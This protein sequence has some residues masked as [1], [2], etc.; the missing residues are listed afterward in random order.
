MES[1]PLCV[2]ANDA[3]SGGLENEER[4]EDPTQQHLGDIA[5]NFPRQVFARSKSLY[6]N[7]SRET[8]DSIL[9]D[10]VTR[11]TSHGV[12]KETLR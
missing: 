1:A 7:V 3:W 8:E 5:G 6:S 2:F 4:S 10:P 12:S 11:G 9:S